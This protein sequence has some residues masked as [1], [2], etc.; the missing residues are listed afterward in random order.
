MAKTGRP[1]TK[2]KTQTEEI[3]EEGLEEVVEP[4]LEE[5]AETIVLNEVAEPVLEEVK[6]E[7]PP[8][9]DVQ[10][11]KVEVPELK[12]KV[13]GIVSD[14]NAL[15]LREG[16]N[17]RTGIVTIFQVGTEVEINLDN[18]TDSFYEVTKDGSIGFCLKQ[19]IK[20]G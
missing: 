2:T 18:S 10:P 4:V 20:V 9:V 13:K 1:T 17:I 7:L 8:H 5:A 16:A 19:F 11:D 6:E 15:R 3:L 14:C 12:G